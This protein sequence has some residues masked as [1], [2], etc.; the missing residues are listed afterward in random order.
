VLNNAF[1][2][3]EN[4]SPRGFVRLCKSIAPGT[5]YDTSL[6]YCHLSRDQHPILRD[7][8]IPECAQHRERAVAVFF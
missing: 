4:K 2:C 7:A 3:R 1:A 8:A 6:R 5:D